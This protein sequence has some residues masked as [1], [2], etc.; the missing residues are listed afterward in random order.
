MIKIIIIS[1]LLLILNF[2]EG[3]I[4]LLKYCIGILAAVNVVKFNIDSELTII[5]LLFIYSPT[6]IFYLVKSFSF[7]IKMII[8]KREE[9]KLYEIEAN[10]LIKKAFVE[11]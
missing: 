5:S 7:V 4:K 9:D 1:I 3:K 2:G 11:N 8:Q 6:L 10:R